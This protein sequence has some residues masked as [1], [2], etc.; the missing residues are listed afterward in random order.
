MDDVNPL[1]IVLGALSVFVIGGIWYSALF[2]KPWQRAAGVTDAELQTG[3]ARIFLGAAAFSLVI[4]ATMAP[5]IGTEG[6]AF[7]AAAGAAAGVGWVGCA[8]GIVYLFERRSLALLLIDAGYFAVAFTAMGAII[9]AL[10]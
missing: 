6:P 3:A 2:A 10:Q 4:A 5:F 9:G 1:A 7:G 8:L